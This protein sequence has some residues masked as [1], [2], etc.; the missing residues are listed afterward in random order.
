M[1]KSKN[2]FIV[3]QILERVI[4]YKVW[5]PRMEKAMVR[6]LPNLDIYEKYEVIESLLTSTIFQVRMFGLRV[7]QRTFREKELFEKIAQLS[8]SVQNYTELERWYKILF[9]RYSI[10]CYGQALTKYM[11]IK[12]DAR[13][14]ENHLSAM[15]MPLGGSKKSKKI[16]LKLICQIAVAKGYVN[17]GY[18]V[19]DLAVNRYR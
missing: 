14:L 11:E 12:G 2:F 6:A 7:A 5:D 1:N 15:Q 10:G 19:I 3:E 4:L 18:I 9:S 17:S 13:F 16:I 8:F